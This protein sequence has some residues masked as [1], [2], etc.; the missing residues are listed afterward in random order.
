MKHLLEFSEDQ[1]G[2]PQLYHVAA[3]IVTA[4]VAGA[5]ASVYA[6]GKAKN[7]QQQ[8]VNKSIDQQNKMF[9]Q[10][11][12]FNEPFIDAGK[13]VLPQ[14]NDLTSGDPTK[15]N[16][17]LE[18]LPGYQFA[19]TQGLKSV[20]SGLAARGLGASGAALKGGAQ[21]AE[22]LADTT[23]GNQ[24]N[25]LLDTARLGSDSAKSLG[26]GAITTG[27]NIGSSTIAGG[28][29]GAAS[30][31][32]QGQAVQGGLNSITSGLLINKL[33]GGSQGGSSP[34][35]FA[36]APGSPYARGAG[37]YEGEGPFM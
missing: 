29:A 21:Y 6:A 11:K 27:A 1:I 32:A 8:A 35:A 13:N 17:A 34:D 33:M 20:Q 7:S 15:T 36:G 5:G 4:G 19:R 30:A 12:E 14:I 16:A 22:N 24:F 31:I 25:R 10:S 3:A 2:A 18:Q 37:G 28:N 9:D 26:S 23:F